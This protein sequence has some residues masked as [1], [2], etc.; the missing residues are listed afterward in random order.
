MAS[1]STSDQPYRPVGDMEDACR[2]GRGEIYKIRGDLNTKPALVLHIVLVDVNFGE[3]VM[4][5]VCETKATEA[6]IGAVEQKIREAGLRVHRSDG[7]EY[8]ILGVVGD[9]NR[10]DIYPIGTRVYHR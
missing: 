10:L 3:D 4:I 7:V 5:I 8:T 6:Q 9:R 2:R 1:G